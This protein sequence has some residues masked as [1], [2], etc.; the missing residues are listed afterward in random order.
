MP[1]FTV[2]V[3]TLAII[4][5]PLSAIAQ[6]ARIQ[7]IAGKGKV[8]VQREKRTDWLPVRPATELYQGDQ[9]FPDKG[10]RVYLQC[11]G[12]GTPVL[13]RAGIVSGMGSLCIKWANTEFRGSQAA[14]T[15]GG[16]DASIPYIITPRHAL[17]LSATPLLR[18]NPVSTVTEYNVEVTGPKGLM[19]RTKTKANQI[20]YAGKPLEAGLPYSLIVST[21]TGKSSQEDIA[22]NRQQKASN[23]EFVI[24]RQS[25][26]TLV[27]AQ[28]AKISPT[29][30]SNEASALSLANFYGNYV[31]PESVIS[32]YKLPANTYKTYSLTSE[33]IAL[34]ESLIQQGK[35][36]SLIY[37][38]LGDLYWQTG[39]VRL[40][41]AN[42]LKAIDSVQGLEDMED[43]TL[44]Q[45]SLGQVYAAINE[46]QQALEHYSQAK[47]G[48]IFLG[49]S[50]LVEVLQRRIERL[51]KTA[52]NSAN[53]KN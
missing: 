21:N 31:L 30:L 6:T 38:T 45:Y 20:I 1:K 3:L 12:V 42:Y 28:A 10:V 24:L 29:P 22:P 46:P 15:L 51:K 53:V 25:E 35:Q 47:V 23:L 50:G 32:A 48:Y 14:E 33:A 16:V 7:S 37:R 34:L 27:K 9:I 26:A 8:R 41:E 17:L 49:D 18:W 19:W 5:L 2:L 40:A 43:W 4:T 36:S 11:P 44:A 39:L 13:V 52:V